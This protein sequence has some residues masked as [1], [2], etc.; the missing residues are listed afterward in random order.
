MLVICSV[1]KVLIRDIPDIE[2]GDSHSYCLPC[3]AKLYDELGWDIEDLEKDD[4]DDKTRR[5]MF[6]RKKTL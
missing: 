5:E 6:Q 4:D 3:I 1:C 2:C